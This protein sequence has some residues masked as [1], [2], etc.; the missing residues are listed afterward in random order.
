MALAFSVR[1]LSKRVGGLRARIVTITFDATY[2]TPGYTVTPANC[3][4]PGKILYFGSEVIG[5]HTVSPTISGNN[6]ILKVIVGAAGINA[7][8]ADNLASLEN[9][10]GKFLV[11]G[12]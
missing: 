9:V 1:K 3:G 12:W 5:V 10:V 8:A 7:E 11:L 4:L 6:A 2:A